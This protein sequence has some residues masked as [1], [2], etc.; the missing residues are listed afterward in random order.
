[1]LCQNVLADGISDVFGL[2]EVTDLYKLIQ[3]T[4][5]EFLDR[6]VAEQEEFVDQML[7]MDMF[8]AMTL[9]REGKEEAER[10][11]L[12]ELKENR[13]MARA[14]AKLRDE[15][16]HKGKEPDEAK[17]KERA[18]KTE[19]KDLGTDPWTAE[20]QEMAVSLW[21]PGKPSRTWEL[22][23][24]RRFE[25]TTSTPRYALRTTLPSASTA[26]CSRRSATI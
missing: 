17:L 19:E 1:V 5:Q 2:W 13:R 11:A 3:T 23:G 15:E 24:C 22:T 14:C 6:A 21:A 20:I 8:K 25:A 4:C 10:K 18:A 26:D 7:E 9:N 12:V 16:R